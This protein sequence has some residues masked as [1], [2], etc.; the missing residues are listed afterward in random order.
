MVQGRVCLEF[1]FLFILM[2]I[3][4]VLYIYIGSIYVVF[5]SCVVSNMFFG[6][7]E[8]MRFSDFER[9][10]QDIYYIDYGILGFG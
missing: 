2:N 7:V 8:I 9:C 3:F 6:Q 1:F 5:L 4:I 10:D